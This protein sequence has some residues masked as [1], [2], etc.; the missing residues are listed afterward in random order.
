MAERQSDRPYEASRV[1]VGK[2]KG[3]VVMYIEFKVP[4]VEGIAGMA[5]SLNDIDLHQLGSSILENADS[6]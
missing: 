5:F 1:K 6:P 4:S 3:D 2:V